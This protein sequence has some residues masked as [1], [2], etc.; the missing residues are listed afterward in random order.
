M[1]A[2]LPLA[3]Q[4][5]EQLQVAA[6]DI[7]EYLEV[8]RGRLQYYPKHLSRALSIFIA[9]VEAAKYGIRHLADQYDYNRIWKADKHTPEHSMARQVLEE[10]QLRNVF[11]SIDIHN[12]TGLNPRYACLNRLEPFYQHLARLFSRTVV[13]FLQP[14]SILSHPFARI[15]PSVT[16]ECGK[17]GAQQGTQHAIEYLETCLQLSEF[18]DYP[19]TEHNIDIFR[20][21]VVVKIS[22]DVSIGFD[23]DIAD[24]CLISNIEQLNFTQLPAG[25]TL[26]HMHKND[27]NLLQAWDE[28]GNEVSNQY[29]QLKNGEIRAVI[30]IMPYMLTR[31][32]DIIRQDC[33]CYLMEPMNIRFISSITKSKITA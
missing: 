12:N 7:S 3:E 10:M 4:G 11:A 25:T 23:E 20:N 2:L 17:P 24:I 27:I 9:N 33:L 31:D 18:P 5:L 13:F 1:L 15:C 19:V 22:E 28:Q 30:P 8:I 6:P 21:V 14:D 32:R 16:I 26:A 29:F